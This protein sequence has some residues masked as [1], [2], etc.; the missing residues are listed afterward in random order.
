MEFI[1]YI[2]VVIVYGIVSTVIANSKD[3]VV[4]AGFSGDYCLV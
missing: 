4:L 1:I 3:V 2:F